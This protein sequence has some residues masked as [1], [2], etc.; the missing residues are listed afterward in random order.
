MELLGGGTG[1]Q[2]RDVRIVRGAPTGRHALD[3]AT[4]VFPAVAR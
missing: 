2:R 3:A 4:D 1:T